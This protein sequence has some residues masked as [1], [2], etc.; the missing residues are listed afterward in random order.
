MPDSIHTPQLGAD[1]EGNKSQF[2][3]P[4]II[5]TSNDPQLGSVSRHLSDARFTFLLS[6]SKSLHDVRITHNVW[7]YSRK[8]SYK[9]VK[10]KD[11][12]Q[13]RKVVCFLKTLASCCFHVVFSHHRLNY[14]FK[15]SKNMF[16]NVF[17]HFFTQ[18][19]I[20]CP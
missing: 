11:V 2:S 1:G 6:T 19:Y 10:K 13:M 20:F 8:L 12:I 9:Y 18:Q 3:F 5:N 4:C 15:S 14:C 16:F 17:H 7:H